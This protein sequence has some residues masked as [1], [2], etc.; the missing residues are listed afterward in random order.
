MTDV[1]VA[2]FMTVGI[3][4]LV[5]AYY[6]KKHQQK[7]AGF[8]LAASFTSCA[9]GGSIAPDPTTGGGGGNSQV[10]QVATS[11]VPSPAA[12][13]TPK[14]SPSKPPKVSVYVTAGKWPVSV[15]EGVMDK[16]IRAL[17]NDD[18]Q[19][20][21]ELEDAGMMRTLPAGT[22]VDLVS[23]KPWKEMVEIRPKG[24]RHTY[25]TREEE[26]IEK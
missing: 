13:A 19:T 20:Y 9:V 11:P 14:P 24:S 2:I 8:L 23:V 26:V 21:L 15:S 22:R 17:R 1:L 5:W 3:S 25:W 4:L 16:A 12:T 7:Y 6:R 10:A 18:P